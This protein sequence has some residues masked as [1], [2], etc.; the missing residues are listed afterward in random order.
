MKA[1]KNKV[2]NERL[3]PVELHIRVV[4]AT[5][6]LRRHPSNVLARVFNVAGFAVDAVLRIDDKLRL[7]S[8][9]NDF[10]HTSRAVSL[11]R[12]VKLRQVYPERDAVVF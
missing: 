10:V 11:G 6:A 12:F 5:T 8:F 9:F 4:W 3:I 7:T 1:S 2:L